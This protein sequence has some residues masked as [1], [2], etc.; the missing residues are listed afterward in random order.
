M[1]KIFVLGLIVFALFSCEKDDNTNSISGLYT[2]NS[3]VVGRSQLNF[4]SNTLVVKSENRS[5]PQDTFKYSISNGKIY[6]KPNWTKEIP[7]QSFD[8]EIVDGNTIKIENLYPSIP[9]ASKTYMIY[10]K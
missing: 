8:F 2:E 10:K 6:L 7:E 5:F 1:K 3:P 9:E 4:I